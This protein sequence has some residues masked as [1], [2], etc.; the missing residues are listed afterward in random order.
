MRLAEAHRACGEYDDAIASLTEVFTLDTDPLRRKHANFELAQIQEA[1][2]RQGAALAS[3][4]R[5]AMNPDPTRVPEVEP[6]IKDSVYRTVKLGMELQDYA[7]V[8]MMA[9]QFE[10]VWGV[11]DA[12]SAEIR[13]FRGEAAIEQAKRATATGHG[14][15]S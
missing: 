6:L 14:Q 11:G 2:G 10:E 1:Q 3:Y 7:T 4:L 9:E 15:V 12:W 5:L 13:K 8:I